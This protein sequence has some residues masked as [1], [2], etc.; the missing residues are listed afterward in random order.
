MFNYWFWCHCHVYVYRVKLLR[1]I[2]DG[3][4]FLKFFANFKFHFNS[5]VCKQAGWLYGIAVFFYPPSS[6]ISSCVTVYRAV[7][8]LHTQHS[9]AVQLQGGLLIRGFL[10]INFVLNEINLLLYRAER[11]QT[12]SQ[13][14]V[15]CVMK[16]VCRS[17]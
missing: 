17:K 9:P 1:Y 5:L 11:L 8:C 3:D 16:R 6:R 4:Q 10:I 14:M 15:K 13:A 2:T 12:T 7:M